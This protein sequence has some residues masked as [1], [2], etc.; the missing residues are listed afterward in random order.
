V[1]LLSSNLSHSRNA[2]PNSPADKSSM[3]KAMLKTASGSDH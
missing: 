2:Y 1:L 3:L